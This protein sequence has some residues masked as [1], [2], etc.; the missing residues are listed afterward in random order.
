MPQGVVTRA[1]L[2]IRAKELAATL[3]GANADVRSELLL[4]DESNHLF[5]ILDIAGAGSDG[6]IIDLKTGRD[7]SAEPSPAIEHQMT[8]YAHLFQASYGT[9]PKNVIVF[10]L[11]RGPTEIQVAPS[12]VATLLD[13]IR[14]AQ[15]TERTDARPEA[16]TCRFCP[17]RMTCQ[18]H[19][20]EV[21]GWERPDAIEGAIGNIERSSSG[22]AALLIGGRW[23]TG[24]PEKALPDGTAPGKFARAVR[25]R[26]RNDSE[27]EEWAAGSTTLIRITHAR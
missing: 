7:A 10:S 19:W 6:F 23:L 20:D 1:R 18:P 12:A 24:I 17:K 15:L 22:T 3:S 4:S 16:Y 5:G 8:F 26:R 13:Q 2:K 27:P 25:V 9:F 11:Q 21:P 14:A